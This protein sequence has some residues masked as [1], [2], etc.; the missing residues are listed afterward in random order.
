M[1][2]SEI[3]KKWTGWA[4]DEIEV[5][6]DGDQ[7]VEFALAC[8]ETLPRYTDPNDEDFQAAPN[9][10]ARFQ[11]QKHLPEGFTLIQKNAFDGGKTVQC[12]APIRPS[13]RLVGRSYIHDIFEKTGRS[14]GMV[15]VVHRIEFTNQRGDVVAIVDSK[16]IE[17]L[18]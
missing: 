9:Y 15:F 18:G 4:F 12:K 16:L 6:I 2:I 11:G 17:Q 1:E 3:K 14:G 5:E 10:L 8:G 7:L 13:D